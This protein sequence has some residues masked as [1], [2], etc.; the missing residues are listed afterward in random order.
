[1]LDLK[2]PFPV[3]FDWPRVG[4]LVVGDPQARFLKFCGS[5]AWRLPTNSYPQLCKSLQ[6]RNILG[7]FRKKKREPLEDMG[8]FIESRLVDEGKTLALFEVCWQPFLPRAGCLIP[9]TDYESPH[10]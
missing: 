10:I 9:P 5:M 8:L 6:T 7:S 3:A 4:A 2:A 1:M